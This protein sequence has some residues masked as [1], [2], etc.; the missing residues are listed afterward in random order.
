MFV[1]NSP[2]PEPQSAICSITKGNRQ[3]DSSEQYVQFHAIFFL[4][5]KSLCSQKNPAMAGFQFGLNYFST[6][7]A[8]TAVK[9]APYWIA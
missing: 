2:Q 3:Q 6:L 9:T 7:N 8:K 4:Q 5:K 1:T